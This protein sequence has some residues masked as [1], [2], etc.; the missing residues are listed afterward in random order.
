[1]VS[2]P[3]LPM[4]LPLLL[5]RSLA[6]FVCV[7]ALGLG[8]LLPQ[9]AGAADAKDGQIVR[10]PT[11]RGDGH[12]HVRDCK[13][14]Q[15]PCPANC[16]K[17][18]APG[19]TKRQIDGQNEADAEK[20]W[21]P[22]EYKAKGKKE[23]AWFPREQ[24]G[25]LI[26]MEKGKPVARGRCTVCQGAGHIACRSCK[27]TDKCSTCLGEKQFVRGQNLFTLA[28]AQGREIEA[29]VRSRKADRVTVLRLADLQ[30]FDIPLEKFSAESTERIE[31]R[32]PLE[33]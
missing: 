20:L 31:Q 13:E 29:V 23:T 15:I 4:R 2:N 5:T 21:F 9:E 16:L 14:G 26:E 19:W 17:P 30:I 11:C 27:G 22:Y 7:F 12:C 18:D 24:A 3:C 25:E 10:C 32:F 8:M 6:R 1:M 28:D 33:K